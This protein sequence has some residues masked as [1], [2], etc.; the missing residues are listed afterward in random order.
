MRIPVLV[1]VSDK[2]LWALRP[3]VIQFQKY[4]GDYVKTEVHLAG[5]TAPDYPLP[6]GWQFHRIGAW[7][8]YP[9]NRY[10]DSLLKAMDMTPGEHM[11]LML[12][13]YWLIRPVNFQ[14]VEFLSRYMQYMG[15]VIRM[16][17]TSDRMYAGSPVQEIGGYGYL[18]LINTPAPSQYRL[19]F[20]AGIYNKA[21][22]KEVLIPGETPWEI[23]IKGNERLAKLPYRV[24]GTRQP[25]LRYFIAVEKGH[26]NW[27]DTPWQ[28]PPSRLN[29][30]DRA[31]IENILRGQNGA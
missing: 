4:W 29:P 16:D 21:R 30:E 7:A 1:M 14:A 24:L 25:P 19:S 6:A 28:V 3:F 9:V 10:S 2:N 5:Y 15:D 31:E 12:E 20:Q 27:Q 17:L 26:L 23:E 22:L 8:D 13:D 11:I 18:D